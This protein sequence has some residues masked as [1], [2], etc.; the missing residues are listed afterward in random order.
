MFKF[1]QLV[2][3][4]SDLDFSTDIGDGIEVGVLDNLTRG[5]PSREADGVRGAL[6]EAADVS[7]VIV[8]FLNAN[9]ASV[10]IQGHVIAA[11]SLN[12]TMLGLLS[13]TSTFG[14][15]DDP[16][17]AS[18]LLAEAATDQCL[19][20]LPAQWDHVAFNMDQARKISAVDPQFMQSCP[21]VSQ[22][23]ASQNFSARLLNVF[24]TQLG[25]HICKC[26]GVQQYLLKVGPGTRHAQ[27]FGPLVIKGL[28]E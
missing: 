28:G 7:S 21:P 8:A 6:L 3:R 25:V 24:R 22:E 4:P 12:D 10:P 2:P 1:A 15:F 18:G 5:D 14:P 11:T 17:I 19:R 9:K 20:V 26:L 23:L 13:R 27:Y 16:K